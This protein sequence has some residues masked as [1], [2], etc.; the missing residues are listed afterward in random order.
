MST[1]FVIIFSTILILVSLFSVLIIL[2]QRPS[3]DAGMGAT[4]GSGTVTSIFGG[5]AGNVL[6]Q[7]TVVS[8][9][10]FFTLSCL[11]SML[12]IAREGKKGSVMDF[13][14]S[15]T[16]SS[17][18]SQEE[19]AREEVTGGDDN[20]KEAEIEIKEEEKAEIFLE[21]SEEHSEEI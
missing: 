12:Y 3:E 19:A 11:L 20:P 1:F 15:P 7:W 17:G 6:H 2:M 16:I 13:I 10:L 4:L 8:T 18:L 14:A 5:E 21:N 9:I